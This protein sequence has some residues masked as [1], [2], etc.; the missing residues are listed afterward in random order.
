[1]IL[2]FLPPLFLQKFM[3]IGFVGSETKNGGINAAIIIH[4]ITKLIWMVLVPFALTF[5]EQKEQQVQFLELQALLN[6][7][8]VT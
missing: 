7:F 6:R 1:M 4:I 8:S 2:K 5:Q 3:I